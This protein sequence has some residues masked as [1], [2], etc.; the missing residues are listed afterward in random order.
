MHAEQRQRARHLLASRGIA[1]ALFASPYSVTWLTG[2]AAPIQ[3]GQSPF[4]GGAPLVWYEAGEFTLVAFDGWELSAVSIPLITYPGYMV[5]TPLA[6]HDR[7][8]DIVR[9]L[10]GTAPFAAETQSLPAA[11]LPEGADVTA[12]DGWLDPLRLV[13]T[14]EELTKLRRAFAL[15][16]LAHA[17]A[18]SAA[19]AGAREIDV[20]T[21]AHSAV[22]QA[23]GGRIPFGN[24]CVVSYRENNIGGWP[25]DLPLRPGDT[26]MV[27]LSVRVD[28]Y[29][30]DSCETYYSA[31]PTARQQA[32]RRATADA[33]ELAIS[34]VK[35]GILA[36]E[37]D[38][39]VRACI[40]G[41][42]FPVYPH[43]TGHGVGVSPHESPRLVPYDTTPLAP[44]MVLM[45]EP[46]IYFP[47]EDA[48]R[49]EHAVLV[50]PGGAEILTHHL[51]RPL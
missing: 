5:E 40:A 45:L 37:I 23:A 12:A 30:S 31:A 27:D 38:R 18:K 21:A 39:R 47:R 14:P 33:L 15:T 7:L 8:R 46:G 50:T 4:T 17:A 43:H 9:R 28:G 22:Q 34:L 26:L 48:V 35:P 29:W 16:D 13:K 19:R 6:G 10:T 49:L 11:L 51:P 20:W 25:R 3:L 44:G 36:N 32:M 2:F 24:D 41:A 42:G 1:R